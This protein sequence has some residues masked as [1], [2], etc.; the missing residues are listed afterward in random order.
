MKDQSKPGA[1]GSNDQLGSAR[2]REQIVFEEWLAKARPSGDVES[3][4]RQWEQSGELQDFL[5]AEADRECD[6][7]PL[8]WRCTR[9]KGHDGPCAA[10]ECPEDVSLVERGMARLREA[11]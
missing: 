8:G 4:Q 9:A 10:V 11:A 7:P 5:D 2:E 3:V 6:A 1:I